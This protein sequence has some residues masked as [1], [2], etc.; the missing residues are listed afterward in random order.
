MLRARVRARTGL[1]AGMVYAMTNAAESNEVI[2]F[3]RRTNGTLIRMK[4]YATGGNGTGMR[5]VSTATPQDGI[6]PLAS[7]G[8]LALSRDGRFL[9]A[10]NAG[11]GS[12]SSFRVAP[13]GAL[14]L[15]DVEPSGGAQPN[16]LNAFGSLLYV[17]NVGEASNNFASNIT[18]LR[19]EIDGRL[20]R[21]PGATYSLSTANAQP[22][23]VIFTPDGGHLVVSELTT[24][25]LTVFG[26]NGD[27]TLGSRVINNSSGAGPFGSIFLSSGLLLVAEAG[28][29]A[30]S[31]YS[32]VSASGQLV[33]ISRSV[34]NGQT[35]TCWV[36]AARNGLHAFT[37]NTG[38]GTIAIYSVSSMGVLTLTGSIPSIPN[39]AA[40]PIDSGVSM[41][42][43]NYYVLNGAR[44]SITSFRIR[45]DGRLSRLQVIGGLPTLG[46]QGLAV[47]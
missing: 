36:V 16:S 32:V 42:G 31:S 35:A 2:A 1:R 46:A 5:E 19:I 17:S 12:I 21:I 47:R 27:G 37:S 15:A 43:R 13:T 30:L 28:A 10:V 22:A 44:G 7:Q 14:D 45:N 8:S 24:N 26:V 18:G 41:D 29:N 25:H 34:L 3:R 40:G 9:F 33:P 38:S 20:T 23:R 6:D 39:V 11:S 4:A